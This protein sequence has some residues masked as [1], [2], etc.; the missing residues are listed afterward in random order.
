MVLL[1]MAGMVAVARI[2]IQLTPNVE[3]T[4]I[5][6]RTTWEGA[7]PLEVEQE[8]IDWAT[9]MGTLVVAAAGN[10]NSSTPFY[11]ASYRGV[12]SVAASGPIRASCQ[13]RPSS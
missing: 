5:S 12:L 9:E 6:V 10:N 1:I 11:P 3:D 2:P 8:I 13:P 4:I 7:S